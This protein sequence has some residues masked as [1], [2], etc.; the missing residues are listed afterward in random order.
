MKLR[1]LFVKTFKAEGHDYTDA[2]T[3]DE[4]DIDKTS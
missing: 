4:E 2:K 1:V 3:V